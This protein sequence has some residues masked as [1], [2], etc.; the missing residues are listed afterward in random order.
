MLTYEDSV[1]L[2]VLA[3]LGVV[4]DRPQQDI[5][6]DIGT[7]LVSHPKVEPLRRLLRFGGPTFTEFL[8]SLDDLPARA[9]G[10][11]FVLVLKRLTDPRR[12]Q[13][14]AARLIKRLSQ[15]ITFSGQLCNISVSAGSVLSCDH[16]HADMAC[17]MLE[18]DR[19]LYAAKDRGRG[20]HVAYCGT[21]N[22]AGGCPSKGEDAGPG[23]RR[24]D[25]SGA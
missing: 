14:I 24:P 20:R 17:L 23:A 7:Y 15:S 18:A 6:E 21:L 3:A 22:E 9:G 16:D 5:L 1:T 10:D 8:H 19:A 13:D 4:L 11:E 12:V 2:D 25:R